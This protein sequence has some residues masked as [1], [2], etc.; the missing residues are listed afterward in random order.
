MSVHDE[1]TLNSLKLRMCGIISEIKLRAGECKHTSMKKN[2]SSNNP[3]D[4]SG[5][6]SIFGDDSDSSVSGDCDLEEIPKI[7]PMSDSPPLNLQSDVTEVPTNPPTDVIDLT[8]S[9]V[10]EE[11]VTHADVVEMAKEALVKAATAS[12][13]LEGVRKTREA[14][15]IARAA[16]D[17]TVQLVDNVVDISDDTRS[18][19][20]SLSDQKSYVDQVED[21][22]N[23]SFEFEVSSSDPD[24][25]ITSDPGSGYVSESGYE[26]TSS[27]PQ[28]VTLPVPST[29]MNSS[30]TED[31][32]EMDRSIATRITKEYQDF[33][34]QAA[35]SGFESEADQA[36]QCNDPKVYGFGLSDAEDL[37]EMERAIATRITKKYQEFKEKMETFDEALGKYEDSAKAIISKYSESSPA[38]PLKSVQVSSEGHED[39]GTLTDRS[40]TPRNL[41]WKPETSNLPDKDLI[42]TAVK[43]MQGKRSF[44]DA[45][46]ESSDS[47]A[48]ASKKM[49]RVMREK[50]P[51]LEEKMS[52]SEWDRLRSQWGVSKD[53]TL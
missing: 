11:E 45:D 1:L 47:E 29:L 43:R 14:A 48:E 12:A 5:E 20:S 44:W 7:F 41:N 17:V 39:L 37:D 42:K 15:I 18:V 22:G 21:S 16:V 38:T 33:E 4:D 32:F 49:K 34:T 9:D 3:E 46:D 13:A 36:A 31:P 53:G 26:S 2:S 50:K 51:R 8:L 28:P 40:V 23:D 30:K 35:D 52:A 6:D 27:R 10:D 24:S 19:D 25:A